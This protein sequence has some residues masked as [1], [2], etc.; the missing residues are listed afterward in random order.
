MFGGSSK[1]MQV[2]YCERRWSFFF[3]NVCFLVST[4]FHHSRIPGACGTMA[5]C[6]SMCTP[7]RKSPESRATDSPCPCRSEKP[8]LAS[9][10]AF[11]AICFGVCLYA[12]IFLYFI[13]GIIPEIT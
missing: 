11:G 1:N 3:L 8:R 6:H 4:C 12:N 13:I 9:C 5:T 7:A 2:A 10:Q